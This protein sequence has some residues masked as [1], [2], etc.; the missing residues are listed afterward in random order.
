VSAML[1]LAGTSGASPSLL[2][3]NEVEKGIFGYIPTIA[4]TDPPDGAIVDASTSEI[5]GV[6]TA[7]S[8]AS[9]EVRIKRD[10]QTKYWNGTSWQDAE[11]WV[12][13][14]VGGS[15]PNFT[16]SYNTLGLFKPEHRYTVTAR[17]TD[18]AGYTETSE[19]AKYYTVTHPVGVPGISLWGGVALGLLW[20]ALI[21]WLVRRRS[22]QK[23][24]E[25]T[26]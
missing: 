17:Y 13:A 4:I 15:S 21:V 14:T 23:H 6:I 10:S 16:F 25:R 19:P 7:G 2:L 9:A 3:G 24:K 12:A 26:S 5:R 8:V 22:L 18:D 1:W 11:A 20:L